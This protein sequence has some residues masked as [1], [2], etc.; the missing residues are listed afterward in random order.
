MTSTPAPA[1]DPHPLPP[2][3]SG[4]HLLLTREAVPS[5]GQGA[6]YHQN[7][8]SLTA[9][10]PSSTQTLN[11]A[12]RN[13]QGLSS[14]RTFLRSI[15]LRILALGRLAKRRER[16]EEKKVL[17]SSSRCIAMARLGAHVLPILI[18]VFIIVFN[19]VGMLHGPTI[20][21]IAKL[22]LQ[23]TA[24]LHVRYLIEIELSSST[25]HCAG[26]GYHRKLDTRCPRYNS[27]PDRQRPYSPGAHWLCFFASQSEFP[28]VRRS[29]QH[30]FCKISPESQNCAVLHHQSVLYPHI[31]CRSIFGRAVCT[32]SIMVAKWRHRI[33]HRRH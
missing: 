10:A 22:L 19:A 23:V 33:L 31:R 3:S 15:G 27:P 8:A 16:A 21:S 9:V 7:S 32:N 28:L 14:W 4:T 2:Q 17:V 24:K 6:I 30:I 1:V 29:V 12:Q 18:T 26:V 5:P 13:T 25:D 20:P 11:H